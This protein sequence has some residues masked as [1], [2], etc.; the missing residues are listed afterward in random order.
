MIAEHTIATISIVNED[1]SPSMK[2]MQL[3]V[4]LT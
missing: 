1:I 3:A 4:A 2:E